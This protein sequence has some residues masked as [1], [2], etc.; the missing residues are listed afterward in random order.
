MKIN[1]LL[2]RTI[3][4]SEA[5]GVRLALAAMATVAVAGMT[6]PTALHAQSGQVHGVVT[7]SAGV[8]LSGAM[9]VALAQPDSTLTTFQTSDGNGV[10]VLRDLNPG[11]YLIQVTRLGFATLR[12]EVAVGASAVDAGTFQLNLQAVELNDLVVTLDHLPFQT[13]A[14]T[15]GYNALAFQTRPNA[16]VE[17]LLRLLPGVEVSEGG[18]ITA[19]GETVENV[20]VD[21]REFFGE[22]PTVATRN[23][24]AEAVEKV[25]IYDKQSDMAEFTGIAD[26]EEERTINLELKEDAR[27][28]YFGQVSGGLGMDIEAGHALSGF[29]A[30][31]RPPYTTTSRTPYAG[32]LS[33]NRFSPTTQLAVIASGNNVNQ[34]GF[35]WGDVGFGFGR[36]GGGFG[37]QEGLSE[38]ALLGVNGSRE[39]GNGTWIRSSYNGNM[40]D[41]VLHESFAQEQ[42]LGSGFSSLVDRSTR[43]H[44]DQTSHRANL[45]A[46]VRFSEG[47]ELRLRSNFRSTPSTRHVQD[48]QESARSGGGF[49]NTAVT[50]YT[51]ES[52]TLSGNANLTWRKRL[53]DSGQTLVAS[54]RLN[55][56]DDENTT[57]LQSLLTD[58]A[59]GN[60]GGANSVLQRQERPGNALTHSIRLSLTQ[61]LGETTRLEVYGQ[62]W[63]RRD[64]EEQSIFDIGE[65][66]EVLNDRLSSGYENRYNY[67]EGGLRFNRNTSASNLVLGTEVQRSSL[68]GDVSHLTTTIGRQ[69]THF[70][71]FADYR[72]NLSEGKTLEIE[73]ETDTDEPDI[74]DLQPFV[75]N[76][77]PLRVFE[78]NPDLK[79]EYSH[80]LSGYYRFF[81]NFSF[82]NFSTYWGIEYQPRYIARSRTVTDQ[83]IQ[84]ISPFNAEGAWSG[85]LGSSFGAPLRFMGARIQL[86]YNLGYSNST[87]IINGVENLG[88]DVSH[89]VNFSLE[90]RSKRTADLRGGVRTSFNNV[91]YSL[92]EEL[93]DTYITTS[94]YTNASLYLGPWTIGTEFSFQINDDDLFAGGGEDIA[95][96]EASVYRTILGEQAEVKLTLFDLLGQNQR[97]TYSNS[98]NFLQE[99]RS[100]SIGQYMML[101]FTYYLGKRGAG[102]GMGRGGGRGDRR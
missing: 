64:N 7:D 73:Y 69:Y 37:G 40:L 17:D 28:G 94:V 76:R 44:R 20:L 96:W 84:H 35:R 22:D 16:N 99:R 90:N 21:G 57:H 82:V 92:N 49:L 47:H 34:T 33:V 102:A 98:P 79:P 12:R 74:Q 60:R 48:Y 56:S 8:G 77:D 80:Q 83:G 39:F 58:T 45:N 62:R 23:L 1:G 59:T 18:E 26:G 93:N 72:L 9:V 68:N 86:D 50:D 27:Q 6:S 24:P 61:P 88:R 71:P 54:A 42:L 89:R 53:N 30:A 101:N 95:L 41:N 91:S 25:E 52:E 36:G 15:V 78:G 4:G 67:I 63:E 5:W 10:F 55:M 43:T 65:V 100:E 32:A 38:S 29:G 70:L 97:V 3:I 11:D 81:D 75:D 66:G 46:Q 13:R 2:N 14:D 87:E 51:V 31:P 19:Q 85:W